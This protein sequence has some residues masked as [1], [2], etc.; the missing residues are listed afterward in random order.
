MVD[1]AR[2]T[3]EERNILGG[4]IGTPEMAVVTLW[5]WCP[6]VLRG[7]GYPQCVGRNR[8]RLAIAWVGPPDSE[9]YA[10][11]F[12]EWCKTFGWG[13]RVVVIVQDVPTASE[14]ASAREGC[15]EW[16]LAAPV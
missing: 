5:A 12:A 7:H 3:T 2:L 1:S 10:R 11:G 9:I 8:R 6:R 13:V 15:L 4:K 14:R 16:L